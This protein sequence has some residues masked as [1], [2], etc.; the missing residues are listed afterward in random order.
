MTASKWTFASI[1]SIGSGES[2]LQIQSV[3]HH[4]T[5]L[6]D[7]KS[8]WHQRFEVPASW[9]SDEG[10]SDKHYK[11]TWFGDL[12][13]DI[14]RLH[15]RC[16]EADLHPLSDE[17]LTDR[18]GVVNNLNH[19][20]LHFSMPVE[21]HI[22]HD[23][24]DW[25][26]AYN[27]DRPRHPT[28]MSLQQVAQILQ[29]QDSEV[30]AEHAIATSL[31][32]ITSTYVRRENLSFL[33][34]WHADSGVSSTPTLPELVDC[35][36]MYYPTGPANSK[37]MERL[38]YTPISAMN[39]AL[40]LTMK[41]P[42]RWPGPSN[43]DLTEPTPTE[44]DLSRTLRNL[45]LTTEMSLDSV[46]RSFSHFPSPQ[47]ALLPPSHDSNT[48]STAS[49]LLP[50]CAMTM[51][52]IYDS[53]QIHIVAHI[54]C[55]TDD[56]NQ[57]YLSL[58][59]DTLPFPCRCIGDVPEFIRGRYRVALAL[60]S[61]QQH[62]VRLV[63]LLERVQWPEDVLSS[64]VEILRQWLEDR[65]VGLEIRTESSRGNPQQA[66]ESAGSW[67]KYFETIMPIGSI[68]IQEPARQ[69]THRDV[70]TW[71]QGCH[72]EHPEP[73]SLGEVDQLS[74]QPMLANDTPTSQEGVRG[75]S[76]SSIRPQV[77][78][79]R[80]RCSS[81][82]EWHGPHAPDNCHLCKLT[83]DVELEIRSQFKLTTSIPE[84]EWDFRGFGWR[85]TEN[86]ST[87]SKYF[88]D[89]ATGHLESSHPMSSVTTIPVLPRYRKESD[90][91]V[92]DN[93]KNAVQLLT[94][95]V[96]TIL[97]FLNGCVIGH[98]WLGHSKSQYP[99]YVPRLLIRVNTTEDQIGSLLSLTYLFTPSQQLARELASERLIG[100]AVRRMFSP[101][102][103]YWSAISRPVKGAT[104][105]HCG[106]L[107]LVVFHH[108]D[109]DGS[110]ASVMAA[111]KCI[112]R[113][114]RRTMTFL[115]VKHYKNQG[116]SL[117][118]DL[119]EQECSV[120]VNQKF[121]VLSVLYTSNSFKVDINF[122][123]IE[124]IHSTSRY[125][126]SFINAGVMEI[127]HCRHP[128]GMK[129][130]LSIYQALLFI[131]RHVRLLRNQLKIDAK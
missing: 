50:A 35:A 103:P 62:V 115:L 1:S 106:C 45:A 64:H 32:G 56:N 99:E 93:I 57:S 110:Y 86:T 92:Q 36:L 13:R 109:S 23:R 61:L 41:G 6:Y 117:D 39:P 79:A 113:A 20:P 33:D 105:S 28:H 98:T 31:D 66:Q 89:A 97:L 11:Q 19:H 101:H 75:H 122:P 128:L 46:I 16:I 131:E 123:A 8:S 73:A 51:G 83:D 88:W 59:V 68:D 121:F 40:M 27:S 118:R 77:S 71:L 48:G 84:I 112:T 9:I 69:L 21:R 78:H 94:E 29:Y 90:T 3:Q 81:A 53:E 4:I 127:S 111:R 129:E 124:W 2:D 70:E 100:D 42:T 107:P 12:S 15:L 87:L 14:V 104:V 55:V 49:V 52:L 43:N 47:D 126:W 44:Q 18:A 74:S 114:L 34:L 38:A 119:T 130:W 17:E 102:G 67:Q 96:K 85:P 7:L 24:P 125:R 63:T 26:T 10:S 65:S 72:T 120:Q 22:T 25:G 116:W 30:L 80:S 60:L 5:Y 54:P 82:S 95:R 37:S 76:H 58:V 108:G 91:G